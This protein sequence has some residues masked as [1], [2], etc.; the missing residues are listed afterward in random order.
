MTLD[1]YSEL[2]DVPIIHLHGNLFNG[3]RN[4]IIITDDDYSK[5]RDK[6]NMLFENLKL[7]MAKY[8]FVCIY[9]VSF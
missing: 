8:T 4:R 6:R 3:N 1:D 7:N 9:I 2:F 5:F